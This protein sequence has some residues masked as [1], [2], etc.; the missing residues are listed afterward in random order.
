MSKTFWVHRSAGRILGNANSFSLSVEALVGFDVI[1]VV[2]SFSPGWNFPAAWTE[3]AGLS[4]IPTSAGGTGNGRIRIFKT[5]A[6][7]TSVNFSVSGHSWGAGTVML[8]SLTNTV[9]IEELEGFVNIQPAAFVEVPDKEPGQTV[10]WALCTSGNTS[11]STHQPWVITPDDILQFTSNHP[12]QTGGT[13]TRQTVALDRGS[14]A[15]TG[16]TFQPT[17]VT[18][19][20]FGVLMLE[21]KP[22]GEGLS[23]PWE[24][25]PDDYPFPTNTDKDF[26]G[27]EHPFRFDLSDFGFRFDAAVLCGYA[28]PSLP[29]INQL[30]WEIPFR[31]LISDFGFRFEDEI[32]GGYPFEF[33]RLL[34]PPPPPPPPL[35]EMVS[36]EL[37]SPGRYVG[38]ET[39]ITVSLVLQDV[40][41]GD[42]VTTELYRNGTVHYK[43]FS[44]LIAGATDYSHTIL[45]DIFVGLAVGSFIVRVKLCRDDEFICEA[46]TDYEVVPVPTVAFDLIEPWEIQLPITTPRIIS[47][48]WIMSG[49][50]IS[51]IQG[52]ATL[53]DLPPTAFDLFSHTFHVNFQNVTELAIGEHSIGIN[54]TIISDVYG[55]A[56]ASASSEDILTVLAPIPEPEIT[57]VSLDGVGRYVGNAVPVNVSVGLENIREGDSI[58]IRL[59]QGNSVFYEHNNVFSEGVTAYSRTIAASVFNDLTAGTYTVQIVFIRNYATRAE[60]FTT[61]RLVDLPTLQLLDVSPN[62]I[63]LPVAHPENIEVT[64]QVFGAGVNTVSGMVTLDDTGFS[65]N[66]NLTDSQFTVTLA[67]VENLPPRGFSLSATVTVTSNN[68]GTVVLSE[69]FHNVLRV[70]EE[71]IPIQRNLRSNTLFIYDGFTLVHILQNYISLKWVRRYNRSGE[72]TLHLANTPENVELMKAG[73]IIAKDNDDEAAFI[74]DVVIGENIEVKGAFISKMLSFRVVDF[75]SEELVNLQA[76]ADMLVRN[77][78]INTSAD[79]IIPGLRIATYTI[80]TQFVLARIENS[81][82]EHWLEQQDIGFKVAFLPREQA[83]EFSLFDGRRAAAEFCENFRNVTDQQFFHQTA[84]ARNV[85]MVEGQPIQ[86]DGID[87]PQRNI[88]TVGNAQGLERREAYARSG[89]FPMTDFGHQ[90][91]RQ[92][93][94]V[95]SLDVKIPD[96]YA[97]FEYRADYDVGDIVTIA[98]ESKGVSVTENI[99]E[100]TEFYDKTGFH[101][102]AI[103]G[104]VPRNL[105]MEMREHNNRIDDLTNHPETPPLDLELIKDLVI[106]PIMEEIFDLIEFAPLPDWIYPFENFRELVE[107]TASDILGIVL[108]PEVIRVLEEMLPTIHHGGHI[109]LDRMPTQAEINNMPNNAVVVVYNPNVIFTPSS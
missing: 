29:N 11:Q 92:N 15:A 106:P 7:A 42:G 59:R 75:T 86:Q 33:Y 18:A 67:N 8:L 91:L 83:F 78:F 2:S 76:T 54:A 77:N 41:D 71:I 44:T 39:D 50:G 25:M 23:P 19:T 52:T 10:L 56:S 82:L 93:V 90:F 80:S 28:F 108:R 100:V 24:A 4:G 61:Y 6:T 72:F 34:D 5:T 47:S 22:T 21:V 3:V 26:F 84:Q 32:L 36:V 74:E 16:R 64:L 55:S 103:F 68:Y 97:P 96:P 101:I 45:A 53:G 12:A 46:A 107:K 1:A 62:T 79:R 38:S 37:S 102:Y 88:I 9:D 87:E 81:T 43:H 17:D 13:G 48:R 35:A 31:F 104:R 99:M 20:S 73:Y 70:L 89:R 98:S 66:I 94:P 85:V 40:L 105:L 60:S 27:N 95:K 109:I 30:S 58:I 51:R 65:S 57:S 63:Q 49:I 14:G 69:D